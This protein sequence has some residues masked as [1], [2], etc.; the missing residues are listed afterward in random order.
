MNEKITTY[1]D[2]LLSPAMINRLITTCI[3]VVVLW[4]VYF[5]VKKI[6]KTVASRKLKPPVVN[7]IVK[8]LRY[9]LYVLLVIYVLDVFNINLSALL[10]AAGIAG[11]AIGFAA[12]TTISNIISG[13][14]IITER[15]L[16]IGDFITV[17]DISGTVDSIDLLSVK[18]K[19]PEFQMVR[20]PNQ[21]ILNTNLHNTSFYPTRRI[22]ITV[23][24]AYDTD[25]EKAMSILRS[26]S[27]KSDL[28]L[29]DPE[30]FVFYDG[31]GS[32]AIDLKIAVWF[33]NEDLIA[34][35]NF[36]YV[37]IKKA[38]D[39]AGIEIPFNQLVVTQNT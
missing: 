7:M 37:E 2:E 5:V 25:L 39:E 16:K 6:I 27:G 26:V 20:I 31:F 28:I 3:G 23:S 10:G 38:F 4:L 11:I 15:A 13:F 30:P 29:K 33:K 9:I 32:S 14:F 35:K 17:D 34:V 36:M 22:N 1:F 24:V 18:V 8:I 21:T 19:T 12:Q